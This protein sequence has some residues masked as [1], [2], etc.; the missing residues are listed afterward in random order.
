MSWGQHGAHLGPIGPRWDPC[1]PH[2]PCYQGSF[3]TSCR[4]HAARADNIM[5]RC[6]WNCCTAQHDT[7]SACRVINWHKTPVDAVVQW[8]GNVAICKI[9]AGDNS[10]II[11]C[12]N[13]F[14]LVRR[15]A[16]IWTNEPSLKCVLSRVFSPIIQGTPKYAGKMTA[17]YLWQFISE[18]GWIWWA[19]LWPTNGVLLP[20]GVL[21][22][23]TRLAPKFILLLM[24]MATT[25]QTIIPWT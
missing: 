9:T 17:R 20:P 13:V 18:M 10:A 16:I 8:H 23:A 19:F 11:Y 3:S 22:K 14:T 7:K 4:P 2:E 25:Y 21:T 1:P 5:W 12:G 15:Q 24:K 6:E